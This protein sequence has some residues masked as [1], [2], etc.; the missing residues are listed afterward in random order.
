MRN[1]KPNI[2]TKIYDFFD[3]FGHSIFMICVFV[4][5]GILLYIAFIPNPIKRAGNEKELYRNEKCVIVGT[6]EAAQDFS[7]DKFHRPIVIK[8]WLVQR[9]SD[10]TQFAEL[11]SY[12]DY[13]HWH[14]TREMWY[15]KGIGDTLYFKYIRK[16]RFFTINK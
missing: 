1:S 5:L 13:D 12:D 8:V 14:I 15:S 4:L 6:N 10:A 11:T 2:F 3:V 16:N 7:H 9:V